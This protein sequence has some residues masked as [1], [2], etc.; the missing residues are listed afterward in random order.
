MQVR[1]NYPDEY[2]QQIEGFSG[3]VPIV[4]G[5]PV[6]GIIPSHSSLTS[7]VMAH[8]ALEEGYIS[9]VALERL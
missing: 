1:F 8:T 3:I 9:K 2:L 6:T 5:Y 7:K 4:L